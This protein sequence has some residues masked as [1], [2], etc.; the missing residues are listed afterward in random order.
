MDWFN[1]IGHKCVVR[2]DSICGE[3]DIERVVG[4][5]LPADSGLEFVPYA[6]SSHESK[7]D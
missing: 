2:L 3:V 5:S 1:V 4:S 6:R 7:E